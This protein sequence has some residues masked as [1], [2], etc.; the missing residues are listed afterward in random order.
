MTT[1]DFLALLKGVKR[2]GNN[3]WLALCPGHNDREPSLS[4]KEA[5]GKILVKCF[6]GCEL[7]D[8]L[9]SL[10]LEPKDL[11]LNS[12][13]GIRGNT[14]SGKACQPVNTPQKRAQ[15]ELTGGVSTSVNGVNLDTLAKAKCIPAD[16]LK[17]LGVSD[18]KYNGQPAIKILYYGEDGTEIAIRFRL[19]MTGENRFKW[20]KGG[21]ALPYG[22]NRLAM[23]RKAGWVLIVEGESDCWTCW[24]HGIPAIGAPGKGIWPVSWGEYLK[25]LA[26]FIWQEPDATDFVLRL[27]KSAPDLRYIRAPDGTKDISEA[28]VQGIGVPSWLEKLKAKAE[29]GQELKTQHTNEQLQQLYQEAKAVIEASDPLKVIENAI[30]GLGYGGDIKPALITYLAVTSRLLEMRPGAMP[31]HLLL[32][33]PSS[34]GKSYTLGIIKTLMPSEGYHVIDAGSPRV[35]IYDEAPLEHKA[36]VFGEADSLP[37][38]EDN[39]AASAIRNLLQDHCL[40]YEVTIRDK[41]SG[42]YTTKKINRDG[43]TV[44]ITTSTRALGDQLMTRFFALELGDSR[45]QISAALETQAGLET[46]G[47]PCPDV[48]LV[49]FQAY[50]QLKAPVK[51]NVPY[52]T[53]LAAG[54]SKMASAPR[55]LRDF[56][57]LMSLI[58]AVALI[59][60]HQRKLDTE[61][62][63]V[64]TLTDYEMVQKLVNAM[65]IDSSTGATSDIRRLV[66]AITSLDTKRT[67]GELITNTTLAKHLNIGIKQ[68]ERRAKKARRLGWLVNREQRKYHPA[69]YA[70]GEP[71]P[72]TEG[73]P[74]LGVDIADIVDN[75]PVYAS[76]LENKTADMLTP[77]TN[78]NISPLGMPVEKAIEIWRKEGA[79]VIHLGPGENCLD[80]EKLLKNTNIKPEYLKAVRAW[81][82]NRKGA[83]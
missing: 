13:N 46:K 42:I 51:V 39:P 7:A 38:G 26:V 22:L 12:N 83:F 11:F 57:R 55:I 27:L 6:S 16:Y 21:H 14:T 35:L 41:E 31:V 70:P 40:H 62:R 5:D 75:E 50:L 17:G 23:I 71:M 60:H 52:A 3:G 81:L 19:A 66:E 37:A 47:I 53:E 54:M 76:S 49:A 28:H 10:S 15:K 25:G 44:L 43:P 48:D 61:G 34:G 65:Y 4:I 77:L 80:L 8:I 2:N 82:D 74:M 20:C 59:R 63:I 30:R 33:G 18:F 36:L 9:K 67:D 72:E 32:T 73:L 78:G 58:K 68:A 29:S 45:E 69:D 24:L 79:S 56:A 1:A 64:A